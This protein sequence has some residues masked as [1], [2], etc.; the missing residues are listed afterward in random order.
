MAAIFNLP[1]R[2]LHIEQG[3]VFGLWCDVDLPV[4]YGDAMREYQACSRAV[5]ALDFC[6]FG[7]LGVRGKDCGRYLHNMLSNDVRSLKAGTGCYA[8]LLTHQ[9]RMESDLYVYALPGEF[10][11]ECGPAG[12]VRLLESLNRFIVGDDVTIEDLTGRMGILSLQGPHSREWMEKTAGTP[13]ADMDPLAL[14]VIRGP[15]GD[16]LIVR[17]D[18]T[19][20][21]GFDLWL[22]AGDIR[23]VWIQWRDA[24]IE[25][26]GFE[27][28]N[29]LRTE[30]GIPWYG[31][32]MD[33]RNL[34]MEFG[35]DSAISLN[36]GCYR[37]QEI[38]AR[39]VHRGHLDRRLGCVAIDGGAPPPRH[40]EIRIGGEKIGEVTSSIK[41]PRLG[42]PLA[43]CIIK[44]QFLN[45][46]TV[47]EVECGGTAYAGTITALPLPK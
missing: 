38:V 43:L 2:D 5:G 40:A 30:A 13:L 45:P 15:G 23:S 46:G 16:W 4:H 14:R 31:V 29:C 47:V 3:A 37:G 6:S 35:L 27:A 20:F 7:K 19:G 18:R 44:T 10:M 21:D 24:G 11:L 8:T 33:D 12:K 28:L 22:P 36:K 42:V 1:L 26:V 25:P 34:P 17:R 39:V 9:G 32:D 41:S